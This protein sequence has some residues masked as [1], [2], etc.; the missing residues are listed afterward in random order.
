MEQEGSEHVVMLPGE[1]AV[2]IDPSSASELTD[3]LLRGEDRHATSQPVQDP[4]IY[5]NDKQ[6]QSDFV[7]RRKETPRVLGLQSSR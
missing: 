2:E 1:P 5:L 7:E 4:L 6:K 3:E